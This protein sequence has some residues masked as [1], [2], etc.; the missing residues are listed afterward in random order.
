MHWGDP[1]VNDKGR[2]SLPPYVSYRTFRNFIDGLH[3]GMPSRIDRSYWGNMYS[4]STGTQLMTALRFLSLID[5]K[6]LPTAQLRQLVSAKGAQRT[7][8]LRRI[9][10]SAFSF[11]SEESLDPRVATYA[12]LEEA[13]R[14]TYQLTGEVGRKCIKFYISLQSDAGVPLSPFILK[15]SRMPHS[16][17]NGK[18]KPTAKTEVRKNRNSEIPQATGLVLGPVAWYEMVLTKFPNFDPTWPDEVKLK[19]FEAFN[20]LLERG[21]VSS[22]EET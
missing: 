11:L 9:S 18:K 3:L 20:T 10:Q 8:I 4:G 6:G 16:T 17:A 22:L 15:R 21:S 7:D 1:M 5:S 13:F 12:Q 2:K 14:N 19:W